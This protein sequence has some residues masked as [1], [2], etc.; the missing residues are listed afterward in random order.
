MSGPGEQA[1]C[2]PTNQHHESVPGPVVVTVV[3]SRLRPTGSSLEE[4]PPTCPQLPDG[5]TALEAA[6]WLQGRAVEEGSQGRQGK[7]Q[8]G[9]M[10]ARAPAPGMLRL[11]LPCPSHGGW[12]GSV[13]VKVFGVFHPDRWVLRVTFS[14]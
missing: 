8:G 12:G 13:G 7:G 9:S 4:L 10:G 1:Y 11:D 3:A 5:L 14:L 2:T 6:V